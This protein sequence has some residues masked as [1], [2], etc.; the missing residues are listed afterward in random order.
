MS[1]VLIVVGDRR[2]V[3]AAQ[4]AIDGGHARWTAGWT[5]PWPESVSP[6]QNPQAAGEWLKAQWAAAGLTA[7]SVWV[8]MSREDVVLR[9]LELPN[10][11]DDELADL[12]KFQAAAR[13]SIPID[14]AAL[15]F[16]SLP[17]TPSRPGRDVLSATVSTT[18]LD[19]YRGVLKAAERDLAG[20]TFSSTALAEWT[21]RYS[22][23]RESEA[24][25]TDVSRSG[26]HALVATLT[27][28]GAP[29]HAELTIVL[30]GSKLELA[31]V[32]E[33]QLV[34]GHAARL[35]T[36][37]EDEA[38][39]SIQAEVTRSLVAAERLRP[40]LKLHHVWLVGGQ[41]ALVK[42][43]QEQLGCP[44]EL[45][46][47]LRSSELGECPKPLEAVPADVVL[48]AGAVLARTSGA[49]P[50]VDFLRPRQ[51]P[52]KRDPRKQ[53]IAIVAAA[54]LLGAF[55]VFGGA[56]WRLVSLD[57]Q[58]AALRAEELELNKV[59]VGGRTDL[60][61]AR[62]INDWDIRNVPQL[63]QL[64]ELEGKLP[65]E[66]ERPYLERYDFTSP[67]T[68]TTPPQI[69]TE[70]NARSRDDIEAFKRALDEKRYR[71]QP[72]PYS[73]SRDDDYSVRFKVE[74]EVIPGAKR[75]SQAAAPTASPDENASE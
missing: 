8:V 51:P 59:I 43:L 29:D 71:V 69:K 10:A 17:V 13:S 66:F 60:E 62:V 75:P 21:L 22:K 7:R 11:P 2:R 33:R 24:P 49:A 32:A 61:S 23:R 56:Q 28:R 30:D 46:E 55:V 1:D 36:V 12:V 54:A 67:S 44:V 41:A 31:V 58:I 63:E 18:V 5:S 64:V 70:G 40:D 14:Q 3:S 34:F 68:G 38:L 48:L 19:S 35:S 42:P 53:K 45:V 52:P 50:N 73:V 15:D 4:A 27:R 6:A 39:I 47:P 16:L 20:V 26:A 57:R 37:V 65:G 25:R 72:R 9:H 74:M